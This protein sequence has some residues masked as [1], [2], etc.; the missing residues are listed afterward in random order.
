MTSNFRLFIACHTSS[1]LAIYT[2]SDSHT[3]VNTFDECFVRLLFFSLC[4]LPLNLQCFLFSIVVDKFS[5]NEI[6]RTKIDPSHKWCVQNATFFV[7]LFFILFMI[8]PNLC[9]DSTRTDQHNLRQKRIFNSRTTVKQ[10]NDLT[11]SIQNAA[12]LAIALYFNP[13]MINGRKCGQF[14]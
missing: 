5:L 14:A 1:S 3:H 9:R 10:L 4:G 12:F 11:I 13:L 6:K 7:L 2:Q 8:K